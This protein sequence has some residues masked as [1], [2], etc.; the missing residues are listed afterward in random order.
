M[1]CRSTELGTIDYPLPI[2]LIRNLVLMVL[3]IPRE[4]LERRT[5]RCGVCGYEWRLTTQEWREA[6]QAARSERQ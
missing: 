3:P 1:I 2:R 4:W 6:T 5:V